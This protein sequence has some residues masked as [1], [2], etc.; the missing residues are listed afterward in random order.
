M[1]TGYAPPLKY[2]NSLAI[3]AQR[4]LVYAEIL[5]G[6]LLAVAYFAL[7]RLGLRSRCSM[8]DR[9]I[10]PLTPATPR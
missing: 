2:Q 4:T 7:A 3:N 1:S 9:T 6:V 8:V 10:S 5:K